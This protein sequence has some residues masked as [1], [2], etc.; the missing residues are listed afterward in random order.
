M[1]N[2]DRKVYRQPLKKFKVFENAIEDRKCQDTINVEELKKENRNN[3]GMCKKYANDYILI[4]N[5]YNV[6]LIL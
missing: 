5:D 4:D 6:D 3:L 1:L 2:Y